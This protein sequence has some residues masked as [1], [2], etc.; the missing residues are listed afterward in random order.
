[1]HRIDRYRRNHIEPG[2]VESRTQS[3]APAKRSMPKGLILC[4]FFVLTF[5]N[6]CRVSTIVNCLQVVDRTSAMCRRL[7]RPLSGKKF[8][9]ESGKVAP[10]A[11][12]VG[13]CKW[14]VPTHPRAARTKKKKVSPE[15]RSSPYSKDVD[16]VHMGSVF[17]RT[18]AILG[19]AEL[20]LG[21]RYNFASE[22]N[23]APQRYPALTVGISLT[24][25]ALSALPF[26]LVGKT[27][28]RG[29]EPRDARR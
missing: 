25:S 14:V 22:V 28:I 26:G 18:S 4:L 9:P 29:L 6:I 27:F 5:V 1:M 19:T 11:V 17:S 24:I 21:A 15:T 10:R 20:W 3:P 8:C 23:L 7:N 2:L 13:L 16:N 12:N